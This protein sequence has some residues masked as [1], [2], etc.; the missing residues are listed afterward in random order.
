MKLR[1]RF[2]FRHKLGVGVIEAGGISRHFSEV[3][4]KILVNQIS[5]FLERGVA[6]GQKGRYGRV[7]DG[8]GPRQDGDECC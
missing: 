2:G 7:A 6:F 4:F 5:I 1:H 3:S 8:R